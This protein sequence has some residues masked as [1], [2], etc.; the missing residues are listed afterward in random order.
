VTEK[1][2]AHNRGDFMSKNNKVVFGLY[3]SR[4]EID[5]AIE[6]LKTNRFRSSDVSALLPDTFGTSEFGHKK[7]TKAPEGATAG[8]STGAVIGTTLGW[9]AGLGALAIPGI[10]PLIAAGPIVAALAGMGVGG[11]VGG[12]SGALIG[13]G[14]PEYEAK[15][16]E[17]QIKNGGILLSVHVDDHEWESRAKH[18]LEYTGA[19]DITCTSEEKSDWGTPNRS[20]EKRT[21]VVD[22]EIML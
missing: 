8:A 10:G 4:A 11:A 17:G 3:K 16:F 22:R 14:M 13:F 20:F 6:V 21:D 9:L 5:N 2:K 12:I 19:A 15:R 7:E 1:T 18:I